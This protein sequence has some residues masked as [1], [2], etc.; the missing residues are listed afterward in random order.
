MRT[1]A[2]GE[3]WLEPQTAAHAADMFAL[4]SDPA[5][6]LY[7][8][9]EPPPSLAWLAE[10]F[11]KL[12]TRLSGDGREH[13]LN[14]VI[15]APQHGLVGFVQA[16]VYPDRSANVAYELGREFWG[17]GWAT[18]AT[19]AMLLELESHYAVT[20]YFA[21]VDKRNERSIKL[22]QRLDF[23]IVDSASHPHD[24]VAEGD[25]LFARESATG[26]DRPAQLGR[27]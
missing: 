16:T 15:R 8:D 6:Y 24:T 11:T 12:E 3:L 13:W 23:T 7:L 10:R 1:L 17:R 26:L 14:W 2:A 19:A 18:T 21:T 20:R 4:L 27:A 5:L 9:D 22:L 25:W